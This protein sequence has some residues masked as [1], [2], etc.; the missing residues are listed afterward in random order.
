MSDGTYNRVTFALIAFSILILAC[1][2]AALMG[3]HAGE[4]A[5]ALG[6]II[7]GAIGALGAAAAVY[8][9]LKAQRDDET[10]KVS[11]AVLREVAELSKSPV[12]QLGACCAI[13]QGLVKCPKSDLPQLFAMPRAIIYPA[14]ADRISRLARPTLVVTF[15]AQLQET[16]GMVELVAKSAPT[17]ALVE[18]GHIRQIAGLLIAQC[19]LAALILQEAP[20]APDQETALVAGQRAHL[21]AVME[22]QLSSARLLFPDTDAFQ[23]FPSS[24][25]EPL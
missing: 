1:F 10:E 7:G 16:R 18:T 17:D 2:V 6:N 15:Y 14:V 23:A 20:P 8:L 11:A 22:V 13:Q 19:E 21:L 5:G 3:S 4:V 24:G 25:L 9:T 12:G